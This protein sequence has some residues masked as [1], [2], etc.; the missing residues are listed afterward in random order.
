MHCLGGK[1][2]LACCRPTISSVLCLGSKPTSACHR[3]AIGSLPGL[4]GKPT[5][6]WYRSTTASMV[7]VTLAWCQQCRVWAASRHWP[8]ANCCGCHNPIRHA[9][10][11]SL[12]PHYMQFLHQQFHS[13]PSAFSM[14]FFVVNL[15]CSEKLTTLFS[16][17]EANCEQTSAHINCIKKNA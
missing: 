3:P 7:C 12:M 16:F 2:T 9:G 13:L 5:S 10:V 14:H 8:N 6:P 4:D 11:L 17:L 1:L 15:S